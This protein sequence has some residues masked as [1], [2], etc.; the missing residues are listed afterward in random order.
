MI[1]IAE[2]LPL[3]EARTDPG[4]NCFAPVLQGMPVTAVWIG[5][6]GDGYNFEAF[7]FGEPETRAVI[8]HLWPLTLDPPPDQVDEL[9]EPAEDRW[10]TF[11]ELADLVNRMF[12]EGLMF[13]A[14]AMIAG[15]VQLEPEPG[16]YTS[17]LLVY[18]GT[19]P[20]TAA[21]RRIVPAGDVPRRRLLS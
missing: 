11:D 18:A 7:H 3:S 16:G 6:T 20:N 10:P 2:E 1:T 5:C 12:M 17:L 14:P 19:M 13:S 4:A 8:V 21:A 9:E 15:P